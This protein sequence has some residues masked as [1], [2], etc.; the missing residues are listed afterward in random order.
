MAA[1]TPEAQLAEASAWWTTEIVDIH[2]GKIAMRGYPIQELI[3]KVSFPDMVYLMLRGE[4][5]ERAQAELTNADQR[6]KRTRE[7]R[8]QN[9]VRAR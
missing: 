5:P 8:A 4:L 3:G 9:V 7:L 2:P 1:K 6:L